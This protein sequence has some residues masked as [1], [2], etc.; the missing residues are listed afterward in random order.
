MSDVPYYHVII[1]RFTKELP[2]GYWKRVH[3]I[4]DRIRAEVPGCLEYYQAPNMSGF[5][6]GW[7]HVHL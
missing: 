3:E 4:C 1:K 5:A 6:R 7:T 2:H